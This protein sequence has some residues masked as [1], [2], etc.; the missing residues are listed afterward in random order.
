MIE[1]LTYEYHIVGLLNFATKWD[2]C[3]FLDCKN[4]N[5]IPLTFAFKLNHSMEMTK[6]T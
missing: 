2:G 3:N 6:I 1:K 4:A 5:K